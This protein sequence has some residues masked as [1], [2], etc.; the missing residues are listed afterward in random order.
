MASSANTI[1]IEPIERIRMWESLLVLEIASSVLSSG[2][3][4]EAHERGSTMISNM[5][6]DFAHNP[7]PASPRR[8]SQISLRLDPFVGGPLCCL[9]TLVAVVRVVPIAQ[10][11]KTDIQASVMSS[12]QPAEI[13]TSVVSGRWC[14]FAGFAG[15]WARA[16]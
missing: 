6:F 12:T 13:A 15:D 1:R 3:H 5:D 9:S 16:S 8:Q 2:V 7:M 11:V 10:V 4:P 14:S